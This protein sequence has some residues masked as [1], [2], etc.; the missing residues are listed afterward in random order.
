MDRFLPKGSFEPDEL[1]ALKKL[2]DEVTGQAW[3][4]QTADAKKA[5]AKY[6]FNTFP[7]ATYNAEIHR[8]IVEAAARKFYCVT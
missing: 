6:L 8:S 5:F 1:T 2:F 3:F 4:E 7:A